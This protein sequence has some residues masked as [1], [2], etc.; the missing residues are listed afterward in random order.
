M[1]YLSRLLNGQLDLATG[2]IID[3]RTTNLKPTYPFV[4]VGRA[5]LI[6][7]VPAFF[8]GWAR[9]RALNFPLWSLIFL[10]LPWTPYVY[11][12]FMGF[13]PD[14]PA[15]TDRAIYAPQTVK[16]IA[17]IVGIAFL[18]VVI[19][20]YFFNQYSWYIFLGI[21]LWMGF[22]VGRVFYGQFSAWRS[23]GVTLQPLCFLGLLLWVGA[24]EGLICLIMALPL[25]I[26]MA[27]IG[28]LIG[29]L[30]CGMKPP[31]D[32]KFLLPCITAFTL[33]ILMGAESTFYPP[34]APE[35]AV[36][37]EVVITAPPPVVWDRVIAFSPIGPPEDPLLM[38]GIAYPTRARL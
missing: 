26:I 32:N 6:M 16:R 36:R 33:P 9:S 23:I 1:A 27:A 30:S 34:Q 15:A 28:V 13:L 8:L 25:A 11:L 24:L 37:S 29:Y 12:L 5:A 4:V 19:S 21:P 20:V 31:D 22:S 10:A 17:A 35:H 14:A 2:E 38:W 18:L 7:A 3:M